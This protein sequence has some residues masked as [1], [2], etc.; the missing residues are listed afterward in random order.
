MVPPST[1]YGLFFPRLEVRN[2][3][4]KLQSPIILGTDKAS[5]FKFCTH[6]HR[7]NRNKSRKSPLKILRKIAVCSQ[8]V[9]K[10]FRAPIYGTHCAVI[11]AIA[12]LSCYPRDAMP[13]AVFATATCLSVCPSEHHTHV[14][15]LAER[16]QDREMYT[17]WFLFIKLSVRSA[18]DEDRNK[19]YKDTW[20]KTTQ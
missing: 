17:I 14:F 16:K 2:P 3:H 4:S 13:S 5:D 10:I 19:I 11:F 8:G 18:D 1:P 20:T 9:Q 6:I 12:Q 7:V 15:C